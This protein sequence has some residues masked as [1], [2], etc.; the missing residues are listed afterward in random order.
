[1]T[2]NAHQDQEDGYSLFMAICIIIGLICA[3]IVGTHYD[4]GLVYWLLTNWGQTTEGSV[5]SVALSSGPFEKNFD[6]GPPSLLFK[7]TT[8]FGDFST[9]ILN[10]TSIEGAEFKHEVWF[11]KEK[12]LLEIDQSISLTYFP[13]HPEIAH[14]TS[15]LSDFQFDAKLLKWATSGLCLSI[16]GFLVT[17]HRYRLFKRNMR[18]Y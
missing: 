1:M 8:Y 5:I 17:L 14:P 4:T 2:F 9:A 7:N 11:I 18:R 6:S 15:W 16:F 12:Y 10:F 3:Y 13:W